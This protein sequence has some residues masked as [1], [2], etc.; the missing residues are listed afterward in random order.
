MKKSTLTVTIEEGLRTLDLSL[1][2]TAQQ[3]A[4]ITTRQSEISEI[5]VKEFD[6]LGTLLT[7]ACARNTMIQPLAEN[8]IDLFVLLKPEIG[9]LNTPGSLMRKLLAVLQGHYSNASIETD[10]RSIAIPYA[11][12]SFRVIPSFARENKGYIVADSKNQQWVKTNPNIH[13]YDL[14][15]Q[16]HKHKGLLL[17]VVRIIK[18]WNECNGSLFNNYYLELLLKK[19]LNEIKVNTRV[20]VIKYFFRQAI[21]MLVFTIDDPADY[22]KQME[23]LKD[24]DNMLEAMQNFVDSHAHIVDAE[25]FEEEGNLMQAYKAFGKIFGGYY[26]SYVDMMSKK[27]DANNITGVE[28]LQILRDAT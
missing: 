5:V 28:A 13:Y 7:G 4:M 9:R 11:E 3:N 14:D 20:Q 16:N 26:P 2:I 24:I 22:G 18:Y 25:Q 21:R 27:L 12:F 1:I 10:G 19:T 23:G 17:P 8:R 15:D 6:A